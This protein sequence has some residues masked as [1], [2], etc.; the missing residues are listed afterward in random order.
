MSQWWDI[1]QFQNWTIDI[2]VL[3]DTWLTRVNQV[4]KERGRSS[5]KL[6]QP[7]HVTAAERSEA[8]KR[9]G[10]A[11][12][13]RFTNSSYYN[14]G[15]LVAWFDDRW[16]TFVNNQRATF[17]ENIGYWRLTCKQWDCTQAAI[18]TMRTVFD[19]FISE[20]WTANDAHRRTIIHPSFEI[21]GLWIAI[22]ENKKRLYVTQHYGTQI[23]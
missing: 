4:R 10:V 13:R 17:T 20:E 1:Y 7:L 5:I 19:Y 22:D 11:D 9:K 21:M 6:S 8:M 14:Y 15:Q 16:I 3:Q 2:L 18:K 12:H 23:Q